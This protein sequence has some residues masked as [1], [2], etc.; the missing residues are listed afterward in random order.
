MLENCQ[1]NILR[2][3]LKVP[4]TTP[5]LGILQET[6]VWT[7]DLHLKYKRI[8]LYHNIIQSD[9]KAR[10]AKRVLMEEESQPFNGCWMEQVKKDVDSV[11]LTLNKIKKE[12]KSTI[13][14]AVKES[15]NKEM[16]EMLKTHETKKMRTVMQTE[17][18]RK[19]Y[20]TGNF[21]G[22]EVSEILKL[23]LHMVKMKANY[24]DMNEEH[25]CR[26]CRKEEETT[27]HIFYRCSMM[28]RI[29]EG[30]RIGEGTLESENNEECKKVLKF[31]GLCDSLIW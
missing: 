4:Q 25:V 9:E 19:E 8:M 5:Y 20:M 6:G 12:L 24:R 3:L 28:K 2:R 16:G 31:K 17:Y 30:M 29:R 15:I 18:K 11:S 14:K 7:V 21:S 1:A 22:N 13:K 26:L 23:K 27:E 10:F